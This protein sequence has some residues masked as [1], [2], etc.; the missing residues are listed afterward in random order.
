M[1]LEKLTTGIE[2]PKPKPMVTV[3]YEQLLNAIMDGT[4]KEGERI[5]ESDLS[6]GFGVSR[7][8]IREALRMLEIDGLIA[9]IPYRGVIVSEITPR[10]ACETLEIKAMVEGFAAW[11]GADIFTER[12]I[13]RLESILDEMEGCIKQEQVQGVLE[14][15]LKFHLSLVRSIRNAKLFKYY[16]GVH[17]N[18]RRFYR[19]GLLRQPGWKTSFHEH[20]SILDNIRKK[21]AAAAEATARQ[22]AHNTIDRVL[23]V[24]TERDKSGR[25][26]R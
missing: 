7:S 15:N 21:N 5:V 24:L 9:L 17:Q 2:L 13:G 10:E 1:D 14:A 20:C 18:L 22:H 4:L 12:E 11:R 26:T 6:K 3:I 8:P 23:A 19:I 25:E 16:Q